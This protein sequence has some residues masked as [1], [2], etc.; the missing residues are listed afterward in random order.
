MS[1]VPEFLADWIATQR[2][3]GG[4]GRVPQLERRGHWSFRDE[5]WFARIETHLLLDSSGDE[6]ALYQV[7]LT[8][9][10]APLEGHEADLIGTVTEDDGTQLYVY[11]GPK[12]PAYAWALLRLI[13]DESEAQ[14]SEESEG[15]SAR[16]HRQ[17][18]VDI[19]VVVGSRVLS[20]EQS[21]TSIIYDMVDPDGNAVNPMICKVFRAIHHGENPDVVLQTV[22]AGA[23]SPNVPL[24]VGYVEGSWA[25]PGRP[26]GMATGHLAFA[27]EFLPGVKDA[28][29]VALQAAEGGEDF[30]EPARTLGAATASVHATLASALPTVEATPDVV[31]EIMASLRSRLD[32]ALREVPQLKEHRSAIERVYAAAE[33]VEWPRLQR[34]HGDY[35]LGQVLA[36][37]DRGWVLLDFEGEPLRPMTERSVPDLALRDVAGMLRSF[38]Y[39]AGSIALSGTADDEA[40]SEWAHTARR[41]FLDGYIQES[42]SDVRANRALLDALE[43]DKAVYEAIY[44]IRNRPDW[45]EIPTRAVRRLAMRAIPQT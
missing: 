24:S 28:W 7:P 11:D 12:D 39:V 19:D 45:L 18:G 38:D 43:I 21:N 44:E 33:A 40:A 32:T 13:L 5:G 42:G 26:D 30:S 14:L 41:A 23:G 25:D 37:P 15:S 34:I 8:F 20:G 6:P 17:P 16:G 36:V 4:K 1:A 3:Y 2:W 35:H 27:Q 22:L 10:D 31:S 9:R 29:R